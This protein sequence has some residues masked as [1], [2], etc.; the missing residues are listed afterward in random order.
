MWR[1]DACMNL[2]S[3]V[4][5]PQKHFGNM[6]QLRNWEWRICFTLVHGDTDMQ[7]RRQVPEKLRVSGPG[8]VETPSVNVPPLILLFP[9]APIRQKGSS[10][11]ATVR[12]PEVSEL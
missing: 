10:L 6:L 5:N 1:I 4:P 12:I 3:Y 7:I 8:R 2:A 9:Q 11:M